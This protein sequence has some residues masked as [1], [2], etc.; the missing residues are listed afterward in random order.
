MAP[1]V[2]Y[3][4]GYFH[5]TFGLMSPRRCPCLV[6]GLVPRQC[7]VRD[8]PAQ[9][10]TAQIPLGWATEARDPYTDNRA[11]GARCKT[12]AKE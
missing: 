3:D 2:G 12:F 9:D 11:F 5:S 7:L 4:E 1:A 8:R 10:R 6:A